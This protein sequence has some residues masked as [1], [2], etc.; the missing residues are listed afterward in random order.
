VHEQSQ[1]DKYPPDLAT[2]T[3]A[4]TPD[5]SSDTHMNIHQLVDEPES[6]DYEEY[7][8]ALLTS[9][10]LETNPWIG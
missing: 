5:R 4:T 3:A 1:T 9:L 7:G 2:T 6:M 10:A 8:P